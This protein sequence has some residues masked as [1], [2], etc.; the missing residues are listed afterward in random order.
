MSATAA[1]AHGRRTDELAII[2]AVASNG[3]IGDRN[4]LPWRLPPDLRRFRA[5]TTGHAVLMGRRTW[6]AIGRPLPGRQNVVVTRQPGFVAPGAEVAAS[7]DDALGLVRRPGPAFC[8]GGG[9]LY[10]EAMP[11]AATLFLTEI[12]RAY[13]GDATFPRLDRRAWRE[14]AREPVEAGDDGAPAF[15][16]VTYRRA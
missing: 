12:A 15:A 8:I 16:F 4:R 9:E 6:E 11:R 5:L 7:L 1:V 3:V 14:V 2:A 13:D 10:R